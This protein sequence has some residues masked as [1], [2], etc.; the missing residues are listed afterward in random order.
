MHLY[1]PPPPPLSAEL[2]PVCYVIQVDNIIIRGIAISRSVGGMSVMGGG[3][4]GCGGYT[5]T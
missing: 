2:E 5:A 4:G 1:P 3:G